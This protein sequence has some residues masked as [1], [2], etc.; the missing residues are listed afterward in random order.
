MILLQR[1]EGFFE[2]TEGIAF[3]LNAH[4][5][6]EDF[7]PDDP[8]VPAAG[9]LDCPITC[10]TEAIRRSMPEMVVSGDLDSPEGKLRLW[11]CK[12]SASR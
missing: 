5:S 8:D 2:C 11:V 10:Q 1:P 6:A 9:L 3:A 12:K 4:L 7:S